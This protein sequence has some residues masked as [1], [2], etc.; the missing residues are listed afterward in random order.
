MIARREKNEPVAYLINK[1][2]FYGLDFYV[3]ENTLIPRP[4]TEILVENVISFVKDKVKSKYCS[5]Y[6]FLIVD[7]GTGSGCIPVALAQ[8][9]ENI[10]FLAIDVSEKALSVARENVK[11][12]KLDERIKLREGDLLEDFTGILGMV[13]ENVIIT[14]NLP[15][16][17]K[18]AELMSEVK[19]YEPHLALFAGEDGLDYYRKLLMQARHIQPLAVFL[20]IAPKQVVSLKEVV[21]SLLPEYESEIL[22]DLAGKER[23]FVLKKN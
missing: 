9:L 11:K 5:E 13:E 19:D 16:I 6:D 21:N 7:V 15:Y 14:A 10:D 23:V 8:E 18:E 1:K 2:E 3:D 4:E 12:F 20:E 22:K 17:E